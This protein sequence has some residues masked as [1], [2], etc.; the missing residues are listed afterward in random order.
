MR[1]GRLHR[2]ILQSGAGAA[3]LRDDT[4]GEARLFPSPPVAQFLE[5]RIAAKEIAHQ[6]GELARRRFTA[7]RGVV[8]HGAG[9]RA[10]RDLVGEAHALAVGGVKALNL[11]QPGR[12][13]A[14]RDH[15]LKLEGHCVALHSSVGPVSQAMKSVG[16]RSRT[17]RAKACSWAASSLSAS[18]SMKRSPSMQRNLIEAPSRPSAVLNPTYCYAQL[19]PVVA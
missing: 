16:V 6:C 4:A 7:R 1:G 9:M 12:I 5:R 11:E 19:P 18:T 3:L 10:A 15:G 14:V 17:V 2:R 13:L 8:N